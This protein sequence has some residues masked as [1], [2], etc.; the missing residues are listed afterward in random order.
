MSV[1]FVSSWARPT[2]QNPDA[3]R[4]RP[5]DARHATRECLSRQSSGRAPHSGRG[6]AVFLGTAAAGGADRD[7]AAETGRSVCGPPES[8]T[9]TAAAISA[10]GQRASAS[11][12]LRDPPR[13]R[14][15]DDDDDDGR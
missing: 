5:L 10:T 13:S 6:L 14:R 4:S 11:F 7:L 15:D 8:A 9:T 3:P 2:P 12:E 1:R